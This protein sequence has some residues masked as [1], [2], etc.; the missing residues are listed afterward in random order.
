MAAPDDHRSQFCMPKLYTETWENSS[1][2]DGKIRTRGGITC[3]RPAKFDSGSCNE[4]Q[5]T[6]GSVSHLNYPVAGL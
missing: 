2:I 1:E 4:K 6:D 3:E 5:L